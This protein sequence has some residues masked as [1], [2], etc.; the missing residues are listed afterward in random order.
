VRW[1]RRLSLS[2]K[3][4]IPPLIGVVLVVVLV[5]IFVFVLNQQRRTLSD[6]AGIEFSTIVAL[7]A[8]S[9][10]LAS[11]RAQLQGLLTKV[12]GGADEEFIYIA[13]KPLLGTL[14]D[15]KNTIKQIVSSRK[16]S[17]GDESRYQQIAEVISLYQHS[18]ATAIELASIDTSLSARHMLRADS[19]FAQVDKGFN[20]FINTIE[21]QAE[22]NP[23]GTEFATA[24]ALESV[25]S[26]FASIH[27]QLQELLIKVGGGVDEEFV[28]IASKPLLESLPDIASAIEETAS[29][30]K[31]S[32][33]D[34]QQYQQVNEAISLY[35]YSVATAIEMAP[36]DSALAAR[37][38]ARAD[39]YFVQVDRGFQQ[40]ANTIKQRAHKKLTASIDV[41]DASLYWFIVVALIALSL[42]IIAAGI[43][44]RSLLSGIKQVINAI[45]GLADGDHTTV[46][47]KSDDNEELQSINRALDVL[48][49]NLFDLDR[50]TRQ[51][52]EA[53]SKLALAAKVFDS[54]NEGVV[55]SDK[56]DRIVA[57]NGAFTEITGY[58]EADVIGKIPEFLVHG[59]SD[60]EAVWQELQD[61][62]VWSGEIWQRRRS[63]ESRPVWLTSSRV[64]DPETGGCH[65]V[66]VFSDI[67]AL[68]DSQARVEYLAQHDA[69]TELPNRSLFIGRLNH[70]LDRARRDKSKLSVLF[71]DLDRFKNIN[72]SHGHPLGDELLKEVARR[73]SSV[74]R[75]DDTVARIG[76]DEFVLLLEGSG[77]EA[78]AQRVADKVLRTLAEPI[79]L[80]NK[81]LI[82]TT[83]I[84]IATYPEDGDDWTTL[85]RNADTAMYQAKAGGRDQSYIYTAELTAE[86]LRKL[87]MET[88]LRQALKRQQLHLYYQP[89]MALGGSIVIGFEALLRWHHPERGWI[90]PALFIPIA[91]DIGM[92]ASIG[93][94][95]LSEACRQ[96]SL[97][98][99]QG[100]GDYCISVNLS[101][102]QLTDANLVSRII[103]LLESTGN[104]ANAIEIEVTESAVMEQ[105]DRC[106]AVLTSLHEYGIPIAIDDFG[107][108]YSSL[109]YLKRLPVQKVKIDRSFVKDLP[110]DQDDSAL[111]AA[112]IAMSH[113]LGLVVVGE[114][115]ENADQLEFLRDHDCDSVQGFYLSKPM[116]ADDVAGWL[117]QQ[118]SDRRAYLAG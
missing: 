100:L 48:R 20:D 8:V 18:A 93:D 23:V 76:G 98:R 95:V 43:F 50:E 112:I 87:S 73:I 75:V 72:D 19:Y 59:R 25:S 83:S 99:K 90:S 89:Q 86:T 45:T 7:D 37:H 29:Y 85:I 117:E 52:R 49:N 53:E 22:H 105:A 57:V 70:A 36:F 56:D 88:D 96:A 63:G 68:K 74:V 69:L 108:G 26:N 61:Q 9:N 41:A 39:G 17:D 58:E 65:F 6:V 82:I 91:E 109:S 116:L 42:M 64:K 13:S 92:I 31:L 38:M 2:K 110:H 66:S 40:F 28:Y 11:I 24:V 30:Q 33:S 51:R 10:R 81:E 113:S 4:A 14:L 78:D 80:G 34:K 27:S 54:A 94:W 97:W 111:V 46:I 118:K 114:G 21:L 35:Q 106:I 67:T 101:T 32:V 84:G 15:I 44:S 5:A 12:G 60:Y 102:R 115:V 3:A 107:T 71:L 62:G 77:E 55:I 47:A 1:F 104:S 16:L 103:D 79:L